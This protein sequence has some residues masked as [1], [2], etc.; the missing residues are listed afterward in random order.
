MTKRMCS[1]EGCGRPHLAAGLCSQH[2]QRE[3]FARLATFG[4]GRCQIEACER[5]VWVKAKG[6]CS[7]H[8]HRWQRHG[9]PLGGGPELGRVHRYIQEVVLPYVGEECL[10]WPFQR[11][12]HGQAVLSTGKGSISA[13]RRICEAANGPAPSQE[14][15]CAH[16]CGNGHLG[17]VTKGHLRWATV[18][19]NQMD[20][21]EHGTSNR[22]ERS[23][24][25][26]LKIDEVRE[27]RRLRGNATLGEIA[28]RYGVS[29]SA[30]SAIHLGKTW[31][32]L[33]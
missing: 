28:A 17:C 15:Q 29:P 18:S 10:I 32:W 14:H 6:W 2:Y 12:V 19:E 5:P 9:D 31:S 27:I 4:T 26:K 8:Y 16:R 3:R 33:D 11:N 21:V 25:A 24:A 7:M 22:G 20:R 23:A 30:I 1:V 13:A